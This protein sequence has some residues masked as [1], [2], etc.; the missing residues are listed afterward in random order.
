MLRRRNSRCG[1]GLLV[2]VAVVACEDSPV[3]ADSEAIN[4][5]LTTPTTRARPPTRPSLAE[6]RSAAGRN[7]PGRFRP[8]RERTSTVDL[9]DEQREM[10]RELEAIG[11]LSGSEQARGSGVTIHDREHA[12]PGLNFFASGHAEGATLM[13]MDGRVLHRWEFRFP[14]AFE[15]PPLPHRGK[16]DQWWRRAFLLPNGDV[17]AIITGSGLLRIDSDSNLIWAKSIYA[18]HDLAFE[19]NGDMWVMTRKVHIIPRINVKQPIVEDMLTLLDSAGNEKRRLSLLTAFENSK[20]AQVW[21]R[22][23]RRTGDIFHSNSVE[24]LDGRATAANPAFKEGN[25]LISFL[26]LDAIAIVDPIQAKVVW[27]H[28][29]E[30]HKQHDPKILT[31]GNLLLF[32]NQVFP[33]PSAVLEYEP[34]TMRK[35]WEFR[36]SPAQPFYSKALGTAQRLENGNTL[37]SESDFGRAFEVTPDGNIAWEFHN[38]HHAGE[39]DRFVAALPEVIRLPPDFATAWLDQPTG[40][41]D[42]P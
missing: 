15:T 1:L 7:I 11:Y 2:A 22:T 8:A 32:D 33:R 25:L 37:I 18:H 30:Y 5:E 24:R 19:P 28:S 29:G 14:D 20:F 13:D 10:V 3:P 4:H 9:S 38:P 21:L 27:A 26:G 16:R 40:D 36:G 31:N 23:G 35:V 17:I 42:Q 39:D 41:A 34:S 12:Q 6:R